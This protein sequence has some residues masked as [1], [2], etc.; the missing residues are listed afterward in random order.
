MKRDHR[1]CF[2]MDGGIAL[3]TANRSAMQFIHGALSKYSSPV[4]PEQWKL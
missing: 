2:C 3:A 1:D 4:K